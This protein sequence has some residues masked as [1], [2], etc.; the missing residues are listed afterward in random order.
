M[1]TLLFKPVF[2]EVRIAFARRNPRLMEGINAEEDIKV[3][4]D[5]GRREVNTRPFELEDRTVSFPRQINVI[6][7]LCIIFNRLD[8][9]PLNSE[10]V[11]LID[12]L[13]P[14]FVLGVKLLCIASISTF[15]RTGS[16]PG[17]IFPHKVS[18]MNCGQCCFVEEM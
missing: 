18:C 5:H 2:G 14:W 6:Q 7:I 3:I 13:G 11:L 9:V 4:P 8:C 12:C 1:S 17:L 10:S 15:K 16:G